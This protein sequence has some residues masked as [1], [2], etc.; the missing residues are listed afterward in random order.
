MKTEDTFQKMK[1]KW[2][3]NIKNII[4]ISHQRNANQNHTESLSH[5]SDNGSH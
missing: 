1:Y 4:L 2:P 3:G 5:P